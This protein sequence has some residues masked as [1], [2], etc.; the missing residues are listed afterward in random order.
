MLFNSYEFVFAFLPLS[1]LVY[2]SLRRLGCARA[3]ILALTLL[4][5]GFYGWWNP[6]YLLLIVPLIFVN[7]ALALLIVPR[8]GR[9]RR[10]ARAWM[11]AGV[12][13]NLTVLGWFKYANFFVDNANAL[14]GLELVLAKIVL[15]LGISFFTFQKIAIL[16]DAYRGRLDRLDLVDFSLFVSFFPQLIAGPIVHHSEV[17]PQ[18]RRT[19]TLPPGYLT[20]G[21]TIFVIGLAKKVLLADS[22]APYAT[23]G[24]DAAAAGS[25]LD[26]IASWTSALA[27]TA[28]L[29]FDFSGYS[30]MAIGAALLFGIRLPVNFASPYKAASV[31]DF[32]RRWH[33]T[34]S[35]FLRDYLYFALGGNR[36]GQARGFASLFVTMLLGGLW[37]GANWTFVAWGALHGAYLAVNHAWRACRV[38]FFGESRPGIAERSGAYVLTFIAVVIGWVVFRAADIGSALAVLKGMAGLNGI[39]AASPSFEG[40]ALAFGLLAAAWLAPNTQELTGYVGPEGAHSGGS[41]AAQPAPTL[42][43]PSR[44]WALAAGGVFGVAVLSLSRVSEFLYFQF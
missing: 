30:D 41:S 20:M 24:F 44:R 33:I 43:R 21:L 6:V 1:L 4:S 5:L 25:G 7:Y 19:G 10:F 27:Y 35:R 11:I 34:L 12:A 37:H 31:I 26:F 23:Q 38:R 13:G 9:S 32:W 17:L 42:W 36:H 8:E 16:V 18:F 29:Y 28:Q 15:P 22:V 2:H 14:F 3:A 39:A 40:L